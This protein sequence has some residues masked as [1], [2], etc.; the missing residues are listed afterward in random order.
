MGR[1]IMSIPAPPADFRIPYGGNE[2]QFADLRLPTGKGPHPVVIVIHG[3]FWRAAYDLL[4]A[5]HV[6]AALTRHGAAT[7]NI[8]YR[9]IGNPG[10]AYRGTLEDVANAA[11]HLKKIA[12]LH[13]LD[14]DRVVAI[15]H[16]AGGHLALWLHSIPLHGV[17]SLAGVADLRRAYELKLSNTV[18]GEFLGGSPEQYP[19]RYR[20]ADPIQRLPKHVRTRLVHG[21]KDDTVPIEIAERYEKAARAAGDDCSLLRFDSDH[22]D[23]V[24]PRSAIWPRVSSAILELAGLR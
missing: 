3:G 10:G 15:G 6:A 24:D 20:D 14:L 7:W 18:V 2:F 11:L 17:V 1:D 13:Q 12:T 23:I 5:G 19:E 4:Y 9:R 16:S 22:F 21:E 8:E